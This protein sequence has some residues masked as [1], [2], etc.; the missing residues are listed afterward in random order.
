[1]TQATTRAERMRMPLAREAVTMLTEAR[2]GC[3]RP[4]QLRCT[5]LDTGQVEQVI[6]PCGCTLEATCPAC[7]RRAKT[8]RAE[9][10]AAGWHLEDDP[11]PG[12][13][14]Q[15]VLFLDGKTWPRSAVVADV[16]FEGTCSQRSSPSRSR[17]GF[18]SCRAHQR[19]LAVR[20]GH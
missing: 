8:L 6:I 13:A 18:E 3:I 2:G 5:N 19:E 1:M 12:H 20:H 7:A 9:Q 17:P 16:A 11:D 4:V 10:C 14:A 15:E